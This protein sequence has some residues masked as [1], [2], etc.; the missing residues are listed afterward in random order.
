MFQN[1][2]PDA[3]DTSKICYRA[4][5]KGLIMISLAGNVLRIQ[6][7]LIITYEEIDKGLAIIDEAITEY[8]AGQIPDAVLENCAG[9]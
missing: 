2:T 6:P 5:E 7:P 9:W 3:T 4:Y 1:G 8:E